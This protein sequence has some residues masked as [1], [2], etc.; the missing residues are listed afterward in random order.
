MYY[1]VGAWQRFLAP[2]YLGS[3]YT[4]FYGTLNAP[5]KGVFSISL[6]GMFDTLKHGVLYVASAF[7]FFPGVELVYLT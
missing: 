5:F 1:F 2:L 3:F 6:Q 4:L 7:I